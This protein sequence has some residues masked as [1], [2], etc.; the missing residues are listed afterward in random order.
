MQ[1]YI[2]VRLSQS[3]VVLFAVSIIIFGLAR[4][5]GNPLDLLVPED[6]E[7][8]DI[9]DM[10][11]KWGLD[12]PLH[13]QYFTFLSNALRGDFGK[14][15]R[16]TD[17]DAMQMVMQRFPAT[18][19]LAGLALVIS[20]SI[21]VPVGILSA[22]KKDTP[23]DFT[24]KIFAL[25]GQSAP[26]FWVGIMLMWIF[27]VELGWLPTSGTGEPGFDRVVHLL[28]PAL[29]IGWYQ[30]AALMRLVRSSMLEV[31]DSEF[32]KLA[33]IKGVTETRVVWKHALRNAAIAPITLFGLLVAQLVTG[34]V[35][36]ETVFAYPGVGLLAVDAIR[37]RD[38][39][40]MQTIVVV[41]AV[42]FV[43]VNLLVDII[44]AYVDPRIRYS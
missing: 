38:F 34:T 22:L 17:K 7:P 24:A 30:V 5:S 29:S 28:L 3:L 33:R 37:Y 10:E 39:Q 25:L 12:R 42:I 11:R 43:G 44:Y 36:T 14:S 6:A 8:E 35:V 16:Y 41:F 26:S 2:L 19:L 15:L 9:V 4:L 32:I 40:V 31:L 27:A 18:L 13:V 1:R 20:T 21:A 23:A